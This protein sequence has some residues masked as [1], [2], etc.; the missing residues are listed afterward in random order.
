ME[1]VPSQ[2][3]LVVSASWQTR[4]LLVAQI[5]EMT[6]RDVLSAPGVN[7]ALGLIKLGG[8]DP[9][10]LV[11]DTGEQISCESLEQLLEARIGARFVV[12]GSRLHR[13]TF[14]SLRDRCDAYLLR[15]VTIGTIARV[16]VQILEGR[17]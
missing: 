11:V 2:P 8:I 4:A 14:D 1:K 12:I 13:H 9:A 5:A 6:D 3:I 7:E 17:T 16:V 15:P 10:L